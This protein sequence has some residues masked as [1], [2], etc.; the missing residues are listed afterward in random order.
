MTCSPRSTTT[1]GAG[2]RTTPP[3]CTRSGRSASAPTPP[4][5][6]ACAR[7]RSRGASRTSS[8]RRRGGPARPSWPTPAW[9]EW[10][11]RNWDAVAEVARA[12]TTQTNEAG[13]CATWMPRLSRI[14]GPVALLE[15]GAAAGLCLFPDRYGY[16]YTTP[17]GIRRLQP[18]EPAGVT[19]PCR[20]DDADAVPAALPRRRVAARH[21]P[22]SDRRLG[23]RADR[24]A[25]HAD[26]AGPRARRAGGAPAGGGGGRGRR[27]AARSPA[28]TCS[29]CCTRSPRRRPPRRRSWCSTAPCCSTSTR[30][31]GG[32][33]PTSSRASARPID[34]RVVWLSNETVGT[35]DEIDAQVPAGA[36]HV[37]PLRADGERPGR[38]PRRPARRRVRDGAVPPAESAA[39]R[40]GSSGARA[41]ARRRRRAPA[42]DPVVRRDR[43][44]TR[45]RG[46]H[47]RARPAAR[48]HASPPRPCA[49]PPST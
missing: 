16:E 34:R 44:G 23:S 48:A 15:V 40:P 9:R 14:D 4:C 22:R 17:S 39:V 27:S 13:R 43:G 11:L 29:S 41:T 38:R 28:A 8:S 2:G 45:R 35:L 24:L 46:R 3:P 5:S 47:R 18:P 36:G 31:S 26:L 12:R 19:L 20:I 32:A 21:R 25:R 1:S 49:T 10:L 7:C 6:I 30:R 33:S 42:G 37:A